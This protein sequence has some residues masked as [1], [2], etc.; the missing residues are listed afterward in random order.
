MRRMIIMTESTANEIPKMKINTIE[1]RT[2]VMLEFSPTDANAPPPTPENASM[3]FMA[4]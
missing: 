1:V 4:I 2:R 3:L